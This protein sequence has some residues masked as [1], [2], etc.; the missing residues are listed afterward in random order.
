MIDPQ[1]LIA[2]S[3]SVFIVFLTIAF[4]IRKKEK[5][6]LYFVILASLLPLI[7]LLRKGVHQS[8]DFAINISKA[9]D[10]WNSLSYGIFPVHW[11]SILNATYGYPL[12]LFTYPLPYYAIALPKFLG[13]SFI[14]SEKF[15]IAVVFILSGIGMYLLLKQFLNRNSSSLGAILY[16]FAP[17]HLVDMHF[18][19]ALGE[20][21]AFA[22]L[23]FV[24]YSIF[25]IKTNASRRYI[26][27]LFVAY[28]CLMLSHQAATLIA[29][30]FIIITPL[31]LTINKKKLLHIYIALFCAFLA[32]SFYWLP[33]LEGTAHTLQVEFAKSISFEDPKLYFISPWRFGF[34]Y[35]GPVG[36]LSFPMGFVQ[37]I[38]TVFLTVSLMKDKVNKRLKKISFILLF[39][40]WFF[41][42]LLFPFSD[43]L[44][45]KLPLMTNFQFSYR[46]M[47]PISFI[48]AIIGA[49]SVDKIKN[50][51]VVYLI[52]IVAM[53]LTILNW[54]TRAMLTDI[55]DSYLMH[56][57]PLTTAEAEGLQPAAPINRNLH[58]I[59]EKT[60]PIG[61]LEVENGLATV[62]VISKTPTKHIYLLNVAKKSAFVENTYYFPGWNL[63]VNGK[64]HHFTYIDSQKSDKIRF[65]LLP[66]E[67]DV[68]LSFEATPIIKFANIL[69]I[70]G[71]IMLSSYLI[72]PQ[73]RK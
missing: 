8:G 43:F 70:L 41:V 29:T 26:T 11:A 71:I 38:L 55:T 68:L 30:P 10:L 53:L 4:L 66:G 37:I 20:L 45:K 1:K 35:Q 57:A 32:S 49:I 33:V 56:H 21:F 67:Y 28:F 2:T 48:L 58:N 25:K 13:I 18:R 52:A 51:K 36:Q 7:S 44:W 19:I 24:F 17:Y 59:W 42:F 39:I 47:L 16:L 6:G 40:L 61:P 23:P 50:S 62:S 9:Y 14:A 60:P 22:F 73:R 65:V 72:I 15:W 5:F 3:I 12:F 64:K 31:F 27:L 63:Y 46:M 69:S 34:L 54:G